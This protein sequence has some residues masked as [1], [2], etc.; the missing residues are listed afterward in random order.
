MMILRSSPASPFGRKIKLAAAILGLSE[1]I[2]I[3]AADTTNPSDSLREQ[4]PLGKIP[5]LI[6]ENGEAIYDSRVIL[7]YLDH[8]AGGGKLIPAGPTRFAALTRAALADGIMDAAI[9]RVYEVRMREE[10]KQSPKWIDHQAAKVARALAYAEAN[11]P[12]AADR[13]IA[14]VG[15][16]CAL[17]YLDLRFA[18]E[19]RVGHP[20]L[21]AWLDGFAAS[22]PAFE[23]TRF[24]G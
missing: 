8:I 17:G 7:E 19:W 5:I 11:P 4:N 2:Q 12:G 21:A 13:D 24:K 16:A 1:R 20:K 9:L 14:A 6:L 15:M 23:A 3:L 22:V 18:G 10:G